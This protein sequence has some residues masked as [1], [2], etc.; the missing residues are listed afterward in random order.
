[1][2]H[3]IKEWVA[4]APDARQRELRQAVH[5][6]LVAVAEF[7]RAGLE[8]VMKGGILLAVE[9]AGDRY[10][11]DVDFSTRARLNEVPPER[12]ESVLNAALAQAADSLD[13]GL[14]ARVQSRALIPPGEERTWPT[15][16]LSVGYAPILDD[17]RH[18]RLAGGQATDVLSVEISYN[19]VITGSEWIALGDGLEVEASTLVDLVAEKYR[20]MLQ[21]PIRNRVRRQ[22]AYDLYCLL[23]ARSRELDEVRAQVRE[24]LI[25]K[26]EGR[27]I[28]VTPDALRDPEV[29]R[30]SREEYPQLA[31][32][33]RRALPEFGE[34]YERV[35]RYYEGMWGGCDGPAAG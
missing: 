18:G 4:A 6:V 25:R 33:I 35:R 9:Y 10:T 21:Q 13:Y 32:E 28:R 7:R 15:L 12:F 24:A 19:E 34:V 16:R 17:K 23:E 11:K 8:V 27:G 30:R 31:A 26:S 3:P 14:D 5:T 29:E 20:A 2:R 22:D 1:M